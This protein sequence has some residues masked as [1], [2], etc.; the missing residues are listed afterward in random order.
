MRSSPEAYL[1]AAKLAA[2][3][4]GVFREQETGEIWAQRLTPW[5]A[6]VANEAVDW[7]IDNTD[8]PTVRLL[9]ERCKALL[10]ARR[11]PEL[12][13]YTEPSEEDKAFLREQMPIDIARLKQESAER[14]AE[15]LEAEAQQREIA[16]SK[17]IDEPFPCG[18]RGCKLQTT[19]REQ[20]RGDHVHS[21]KEPA[22]TKGGKA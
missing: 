18:I 1:M 3:F 15:E 13:E 14:R 20:M 7:L 6:D 9:R 16:R 2:A 11:Q 21:S 4:P 17:E 12:P 22:T 5:P 10:E 8:R 19:I